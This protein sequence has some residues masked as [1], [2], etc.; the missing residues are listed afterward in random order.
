[1]RNIPLLAEPSRRHFHWE[2]AVDHDSS[3]N[4]A[5]ERRRA[6]ARESLRESWRRAEAAGLDAMTDEE[7]NREI[8]EARKEIDRKA[9]SSGTGVRKA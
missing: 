8:A 7:I 9:N 1:M 2:A 4:E 6:E 3:N 5:L